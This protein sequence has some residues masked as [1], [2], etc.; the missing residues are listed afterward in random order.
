MYNVHNIV[1]LVIIYPLFDKKQFLILR[2]NNHKQ[3]YRNHSGHFKS[4]N[5]LEAV[6]TTEW[7]MK[8]I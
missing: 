5:L 7:T 1:F 3:S 2:E 6:A 4:I 8:K